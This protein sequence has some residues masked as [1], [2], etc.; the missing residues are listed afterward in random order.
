MENKLTTIDGK[1]MVFEHNHQQLK[2][3]VAQDWIQPLVW[4]NL[5][6]CSADLWGPTFSLVDRVWEDSSA[7][8]PS[9]DRDRIA[10]PVWNREIG[11][12]NSNNSALC[13]ICE[14]GISK[15]YMYIYLYIYIFIYIYIYNWPGLQSDLGSMEQFIYE[16]KQVYG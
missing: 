3:W 4:A 5:Q 16:Y 8:K 15:Y 10:A 14:V 11:A 6:Q 2:I 13:R 9:P 1:I 12:H 7:G